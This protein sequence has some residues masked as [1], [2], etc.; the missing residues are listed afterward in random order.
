MSKICVIGAGVVG[1]SCAS[2]LYDEFRDTI[3]LT[4]MADS[5]LDETTSFHC[6][7]LW[8]P[9]QIAGTEDHKINEWGRISFDHFAELYMSADAGIAGVQMMTCYKLRESEQALVVPTWSDIV[10][11]FNILS[12]ADM[13]KLGVPARFTKGYSFE[14]F[15][16]D[17]KYYLKYLTEKLRAGG[18]RFVQRKLH[19]LEELRP[20]PGELDSGFDIVVN[21]AGL[22][23][24]QLLADPH[25]YPVRGQ[26]LR[27]R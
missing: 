21:C 22:G 26:V 13:R 20:R 23:A 10:N 4:V 7:G 16:V 2:K 25:V 11:N 5:F 27:V 24:G 14:T 17:Q 18:V 19:S 12:S 1:L 9:Y 15:V 8:E 3:Q 6:G